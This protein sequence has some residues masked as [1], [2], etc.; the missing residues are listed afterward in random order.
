M[1]CLIVRLSLMVAR[2]LKWP[3]VYVWFGDDYMLCLLE[4]SQLCT[5]NLVTTTCSPFSRWASCVRVIWWRLHALPSR[6]EP[7]VYVWFGDVHMLSFLEMSQLFTC[8]L[9]TSTCFPFSRWANCLRVIWWRPHALLSRGEPAVYVWFG[10]V[11][12]LS[13][14][15]VSQL[16][17]CDLVTSTGFPFSRWA[18]CVRV[19]WW[20]P[21]AFLSRGEPAVYVWF[22]DVHMLSLFALLFP[23]FLSRCK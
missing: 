1:V 12:T 8:D 21:H 3:A 13:F 14:L 6:G 19:I 9:V 15:E 7:V 18:S 22:G 5:C 10:D 20:R 11:H 16:C 2:G 17:T 4:V 23:S